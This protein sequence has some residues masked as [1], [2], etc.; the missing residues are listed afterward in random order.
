MSSIKN[1]SQLNHSVPLP[2]SNSREAKNMRAVFLQA[3][4]AAS[5]VRKIFTVTYQIEEDGEFR[6]LLLALAEADAC[7]ESFLRGM[8]A[9]LPEENEM[10]IIKKRVK[11][12]VVEVSGHARHLL[13]RGQAESLR[14]ELESIVD[15]AAQVWKSIQ[16]KES[17]FETDAD[18]RYDTQWQ[19]R[20]VE[21]SSYENDALTLRDV[22][23]TSYAQND[24][25]IVL[26]PR[27]YIVKEEIDTPVFPG[28]V[29]Q[30]SQ[31]VR[32]REELDRTR[33]TSRLFERVSSMRKHHQRR[34]SMPDAPRRHT[35]E[36]NGFAG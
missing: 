12:V 2:P 5:L 15:K 9:S 3:I 30:S 25:E 6:D 31:M 32:A 4:L 35:N 24:A 13:G 28:V 36:V 10:T 19:W 21:F 22:P 20:A 18:T 34:A 17:R 29:L 14:S 26:F 16:R 1:L 7:K 27:V 23:A 11:A 8:L 33:K